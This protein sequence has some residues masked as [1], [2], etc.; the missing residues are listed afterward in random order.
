M[1]VL[2]IMVAVCILAV[3]VVGAQE[4]PPAKVMVAKITR[5]SV[6]ENKGFLGLLHYDRTSQVSSETAGLVES[7]AVGEGD[8]VKKDAPLVRLNTEMLDTD[9]GISRTRLA[10]IELRRQHAEKEFNRLRA[11]YLEEAI[12]EKDYDEASYVL[13]DYLKE[14]QVAEE[15]LAALLIRK[16]KSVITAPFDGVIVEKNVDVGDWVQQGKQLVRLASSADLVV[17]VPV[18]ET[19]LQFVTIGD[20]VVVRITAFDR[21]LIGTINDIDPTADAKTKN[22][23]LKV[24]IP[25]PEQMAENMSATVFIP[26]SA[27]REL[28]IIPRDALIKFQGK[29]FV[30]TVKEDKAAILPVNIVAYQGDQVGADNPNLVSGMVVVVDGNERLRPEQA[31]VV[32]GEK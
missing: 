25:I 20:K 9:I 2:M 29:D 12:S 18:A 14:K 16:R 32:A 27:K 26:T 4:P 30:Y 17:R 10:Q 23:F 24:G 31:V 13:Q 3:S 8:R 1:R 5:A 15:Q 7:V 22:V 6:S 28:A 21:E 19:V 11:V